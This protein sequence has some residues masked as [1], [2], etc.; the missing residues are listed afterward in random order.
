MGGRPAHPTPP[1]EYFAF[2]GDNLCAQLT[3]FILHDSKII[4]DNAGCKRH[5]ET[6][7]VC[8]TCG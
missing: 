7:G 6:T 4:A 1:G 5:Y 2:V 3:Q 8:T